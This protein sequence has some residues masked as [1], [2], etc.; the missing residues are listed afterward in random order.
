MLCRLENK[1]KQ[2]VILSSRRHLVFLC[3]FI[4]GENYVCLI[5]EMI[6]GLVLASY[7]DYFIQE[8]NLQVNQKVSGLMNSTMS[9]GV[10]SII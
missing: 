9:F 1:E 7:Q 6:S 2:G 10:H 3:I 8:I 5:T 4:I